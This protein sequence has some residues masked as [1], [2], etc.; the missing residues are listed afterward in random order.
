MANDF[1]F[2]F[3]VLQAMICNQA[4]NW[5]RLL[6]SQHNLPS[7]KVRKKKQLES[8]QWRLNRSSGEAGFVETNRQIAPISSSAKISRIPE[9]QT[10]YTNYGATVSSGK[11]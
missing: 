11:Q 1:L 7:S 3:S 4:T 8:R 6:P 5:P 10:Y 9:F 2:F